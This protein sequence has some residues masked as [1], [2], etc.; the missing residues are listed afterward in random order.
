[1]TR[2]LSVRV[3]VRV[4]VAMAR[5]GSMVRLYSFPKAWRTAED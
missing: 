1:M 5:A 3:R 4:S 2:S